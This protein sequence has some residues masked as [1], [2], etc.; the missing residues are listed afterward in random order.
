MR[1]AAK[2]PFEPTSSSSSTRHEDLALLVVGSGPRRVHHVGCA[3]LQWWQPRRGERPLW[4]VPQRWQWRA[5][6]FFTLHFIVA[7]PQLAHHQ[8][9]HPHYA[10]PPTHARSGMPADAAQLAHL[11][12]TS[13][14]IKHTRSCSDTLPC[15]QVGRRVPDCAMVFQSITNTHVSL[16][17]TRR[18]QHAHYSDDHCINQIPTPLFRPPRWWRTPGVCHL[19]PTPGL[20]ATPL[21]R[22]AK[23]HRRCSRPQ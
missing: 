23:P 2:P 14:N 10:L 20:P 22:S 7:I 4:R 19:A 9:Q 5:N 12:P 11:P 13:I 6:T 15:H 17:E 8:Q 1:V 3:R 21:G 16:S 18:I